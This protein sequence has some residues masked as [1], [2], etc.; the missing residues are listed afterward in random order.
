[1]NFNLA[2]LFRLPK[3]FFASLSSTPKYAKLELQRI[4]DD[5]LLVDYDAS[6]RACIARIC[7]QKF[8]CNLE[9]CIK[10][11]IQCDEGY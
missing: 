9:L 10:L 2:F 6:V 8:V 11:G 4:P 7:L 3:F 1:M 5:G